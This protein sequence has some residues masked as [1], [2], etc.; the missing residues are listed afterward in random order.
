MRL[1]TAKTDANMTILYPV[2]R[3]ERSIEYSLGGPRPRQW[4]RPIAPAAPEVAGPK[5]A[6]KLLILFL[7]VLYSNVSVIFALDA[8]RPAL[9]IA[10]AALGMM[11][12]EL[13][14]LR[15]SFKL[16]WPQSAMVIAFFGA[17]VVS[18][19]SAFWVSHALDQ[20]VDVGKI[21][22]VYLLLENVI[23]CEKRL[24]GIMFTL[25]IGGI[26]PAI[27]TIG[28]YKEGILVEHSRAAW[29]G[30]FGNPNE[31]A[32]ALTILVPIAL[33]LASRSRWIVRIG[34]WVILALYMLAI[35]LTFSRGGILALFAVLALMAWKQKSV[36]IRAGLAAGMVGGLIVIGTFWTRS[37]GGFSN[38]NQDGSVQERMVTLEAGMRM[39]LRNPLLGVGPGDSS[40]AYA[41]YAGRDANCGCH[42]QLVVHNAYI[43]SLAEVG[44]V[45]SIPLMLFIFV[46]LYQAWKLEA[47]P[48][49]PYAVAL[50]LSMWGVVLCFI[51]GG[52]IY[53][54]WPYILVGV[55]AAAKRI[56]E[57]R[58]MEAVH[59]V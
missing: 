55:I 24:R 52:F 1:L 43:Q 21:V 2:G 18:T 8:Y 46:S 19:P 11:V 12:I 3:M 17:C 42:D 15:Q 4:T 41:L 6:F 9:L 7:L 16:M 30:I 5:I 33:M 25:V 37:S 50:E 58:R 54:W 35:F 29:R 48:I 10:V 51:S 26:F 32:Y 53:T 47:G 38:I 28:H 44:I 34:L 20:T 14:Q 31:V 40:V 49:G 27:G 13:G 45:G 22:L 56:S 39:F 57:A 23:T 36:L 59:G